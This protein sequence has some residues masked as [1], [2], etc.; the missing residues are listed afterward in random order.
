MPGC[1]VTRGIAHE[2][3][4]ADIVT[5]QHHEVGIHHSCQL[6]SDRAG[7]QECGMLRLTR[8][9]VSSKS[10]LGCREMSRS[11]H[12]HTLLSMSALR[13]IPKPF[14]PFGKGDLGSQDLGFRAFRAQGL[15]GLEASLAL[16]AQRGRAACFT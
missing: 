1:A 7:K 11:H 6:R 2:N 13:L 5:H 9:T 4:C 10:R 15:D 3:S 14:E 16:S 12:L 8:S